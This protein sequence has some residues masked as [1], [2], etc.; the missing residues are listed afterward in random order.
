VRTADDVKHI[1]ELISKYN[2]D[3]PVIAKIEKPKAVKNIDAIIQIADGIM[4]ARGDLGVELRPEK[5]PMVQKTIIHKTVNAN[6]PVITAT[7]ML[8]TM[9]NNPIPTRAEASDVANAIFDGTDAVMLSGETAIG[10]YPVKAVQMMSRIAAEAE[11]SAFMKFNIWHEKDKRNLVVHAVAQSAVNIHHEINAR[12]IL[13]FSVSGKTTK[14]I[15]K[16]RPSSPV[17]AFSPSVDIYNR[18]ALIWGITP[19]LIRPITN[20]KKLIE[21]AEKM[22]IDNHCIRK[23]DLVIIVTGLALTR[24]STNLI[25]LHL[26]GHED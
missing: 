14:L 23:N 8:E 16:Q 7:Q 5:V 19:F 24:G 13:S 1:K 22:L 10:K 15:S 9:C 6:K 11:K 18:N 12:A 4:V 20:T 2:V 25:K 21:A 17:Y 3:I 26:V